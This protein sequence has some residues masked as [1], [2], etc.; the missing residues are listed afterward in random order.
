MEALRASF[1]HGDDPLA[2]DPWRAY[3]DRK[4]FRRAEELSPN[5]SKPRPPQKPL[6]H[7]SGGQWRPSRKPDPMIPF[8]TR[9]FPT[10]V[11]RLRHVLSLKD[12]A[13]EG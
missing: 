8:L 1:E 7:I 5:T 11:P 6:Q 10:P 9:F 12:W 3:P 2:G 4:H 13:D